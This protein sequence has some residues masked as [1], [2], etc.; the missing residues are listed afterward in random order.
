MNG[1]WITPDEAADMFCM[2]TLWDWLYEYQDIHPMN[3]LVTQSW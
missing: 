1:N 2:Q 3:I